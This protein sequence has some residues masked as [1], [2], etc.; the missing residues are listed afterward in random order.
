MARACIYLKSDSQSA[1]YT[2][3][4]YYFLIL[5]RE[6]AISE[7]SRGFHDESYEIISNQMRA[8]RNS[9]SSIESTSPCV[10]LTCFQCKSFH[11]LD[12]PDKKRTNRRKRCAAIS[13]HST[14]E[15]YAAQN[16]NY[17]AKTLV[18]VQICRDT[19]LL[20]YLFNV[21]IFSYHLFIIAAHRGALSNWKI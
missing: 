4:K 5:Q 10:V 9:R 21:T 15:N 20:F 19:E 14:S 1:C 17:E 3:E 16:C 18:K 8:R 13:A 11:K 12:I 7:A 6:T 2:R